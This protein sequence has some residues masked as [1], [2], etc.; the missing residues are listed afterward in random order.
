MGNKG[1]LKRN[2]ASE[3]YPNAEKNLGINLSPKLLSDLRLKEDTY[4]HSQNTM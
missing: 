4:T 2:D 1:F 3:N